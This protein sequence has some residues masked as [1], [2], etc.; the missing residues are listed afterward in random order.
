[1]P[2]NFSST[3]YDVFKEA[4]HTAATRYLTP[5]APFSAPQARLHEI[6]TGWKAYQKVGDGG[7][8]RKLPGWDLNG[9]RGGY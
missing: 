6:V 2:L 4:A 1:M 5:P 8:G 9:S 7:A 3:C